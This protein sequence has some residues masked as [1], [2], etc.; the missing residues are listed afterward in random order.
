MVFVGIVI[1][2]LL[3]VDDIILMSRCSS[4]LNKE[5]RILKDLYTNMGMSVNTDKTKVMIIKSMRVNYAN[6]VFGNSNLEEMTS[7][8][9]LR[10]EIHHKLN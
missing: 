4:Y 2:L 7:Y 1:I 8:K 6:F 5:L 9:Y 10:I 3:Y